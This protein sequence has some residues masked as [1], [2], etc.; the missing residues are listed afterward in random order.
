MKA[1]LNCI[2][3]MPTLLPSEQELSAVS[4]EYALRLIRKDL[5]IIQIRNLVEGKRI[6]CE[7]YQN[8]QKIHDLYRSIVQY[9]AEKE[10]L[11]AI[12]S[13][14]AQANGK[15]EKIPL[16]NDFFKK[17]INLKEYTDPFEKAAF[18]FS[19]LYLESD[20]SDSMLAAA[21]W[22]SKLF[23]KKVQPH[24]I[25]FPI[26]QVVFQSKQELQ[27]LF[28]SVK[29]GDV[30]GIVEAYGNMM[31]MATAMKKTMA[32]N[33]FLLH[34]KL[35]TQKMYSEEWLNSH[36]EEGENRLKE[37]LV[38]LRETTE[39]DDDEFEKFREMM[40]ILFVP[41]YTD[42]RDLPER[43]LK[44]LQAY[45][46]NQKFDLCKLLYMVVHGRDLCA[47]YQHQKEAFAK[48]R[49]LTDSRL[50][51]FKNSGL[52]S[53]GDQRFLRCLQEIYNAKV[54]K[55][56]N[57]RGPG[58]SKGKLEQKC[59]YVKDNLH[60]FRKAHT[61]FMRGHPFSENSIFSAAEL[62][63]CPEGCP[64]GNTCFLS[65]GVAK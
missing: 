11:K 10:T 52:L 20:R 38:R 48:G 55:H 44:S 32:D 57:L 23:L 25:H 1:S 39:L 59:M 47:E 54:R 65:H 16:A 42:I 40:I 63:P 43:V 28:E 17:A 64:R 30:T 3:L 41:Y 13:A 37:I 34:E 21:C 6:R 9:D 29:G 15:N 50:E 8:I 27:T 31:F 49:F 45:L 2:G 35:M 4:E 26:E 53:F 62:S 12:C 60:A 56:E 5:S 14:V 36:L 58:S 19:V 61:E 46:E 18:I 24:F 51:N 33:F 7:Y 22:F